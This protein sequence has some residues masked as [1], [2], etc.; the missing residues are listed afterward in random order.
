MSSPD[1]RSLREMKADINNLYREESFTDLKVASLRRLT[2]I[3]PD[4]SPDASRPTLYIG[5]T[6]V[7]T[8]AGML[9]IQFQLEAA[10]I[11]EAMGKFPD[12]AKRAVEEMV[13]EVKE[14]QRREASRII[15]PGEGGPGII[16][17]S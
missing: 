2:P 11:E 1:A 10:S 7:M 17:P 13:A 8:S 3:K 6:N 5:Q 14:L 12:A 9:P 15:L 16:K 4:G